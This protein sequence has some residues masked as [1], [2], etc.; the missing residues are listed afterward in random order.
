MVKNVDTIATAR[1][2]KLD[3]QTENT[4]DKES[5]SVAVIVSDKPEVTGKEKALAHSLGMAKSFDVTDEELVRLKADRA[6]FL[7]DIKSLDLNISTSDKR[8]LEYAF[9]IVREARGFEQGNLEAELES[10]VNA[11][12]VI[13]AQESG[14]SDRHMNYL[15]DAFRNVVASAFMRNAQSQARADIYLDTPAGRVL[16]QESSNFDSQLQLGSNQRSKIFSDVFLANLMSHGAKEAF[17]MAWEAVRSAFSVDGSF[18]GYSSEV[19]EEPLEKVLEE[20]N[21]NMTGRTDEANGD[22]TEAQRKMTAMKIA[23][24]ISNGDNVPMQDHRFLAE[25]D[26]N[27]YKAALKASLV[28]ENDDPKDYDSLVDEMLAEENA[29]ANPDIQNPEL[30]ADTE[31]TDT[32]V[33]ESAVA[34][35]D[36]VDAYC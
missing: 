26:S 5:K 17:R 6:D 16:T 9:R 35:F 29:K 13:R 1:F 8:V 15:E 18:R 22:D 4:V 11:F 3:K 10:F 34:S 24:R 36:R 30:A 20:Y 23:R 12:E 27:L 25:Y 32:T 14:D 33:A 28:A 21:A 31:S 2:L 7:N 19:S